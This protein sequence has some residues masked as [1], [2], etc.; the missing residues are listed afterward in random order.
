ML[1]AHFSRLKQTFL[2]DVFCCDFC[3]FSSDVTAGELAYL[4]S[5]EYKEI[6]SR[7]FDKDMCIVNSLAM[8]DYCCE[9]VRCLG[10]AI[11]FVNT[12]KACLFP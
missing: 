2:F 5:C 11:S 6:A 7:L 8:F 3:W 12:K 1:G 10:S 9:Q 4:N